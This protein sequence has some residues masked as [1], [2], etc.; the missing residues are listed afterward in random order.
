M[1]R[2]HKILP[3]LS[4]HSSLL[5]RFVPCSVQKTCRGTLRPAEQGMHYTLQC[6]EAEAEGGGLELF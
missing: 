3:V 5:V 4:T 6:P 1:E 2:L